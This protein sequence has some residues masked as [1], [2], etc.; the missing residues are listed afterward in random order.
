MP[1]EPFTAAALDVP[2]GRIVLVL[3]LTLLVSL[4]AALI[5]RRFVLGGGAAAADDRVLRLKDSLSLGP[6][7]SVLA[8]EAAG[9]TILLASTQDRITFLSD[10]GPVADPTPPPAPPPELPATLE[11]TLV[12]P[13]E[14][15]VQPAFARVLEAARQFQSEGWASAV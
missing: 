14:A 13:T 2:Y 8:V 1:P 6:R 12:T 9:R 3:G 4:A 5:M 15:S 7:R 10:L 11:P